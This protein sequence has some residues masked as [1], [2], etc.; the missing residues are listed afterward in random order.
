MGMCACV[1]MGIC[2]WACVRGYVCMCVHEHVCMG[3]C[4]WVCV[5]GHV[6]MCVHGYLCVGMCAWVCVY[7]CVCMGVCAW[8]RVYG[9]VC[10][11]MCACV[12]VCSSLIIITA[13]PH[14]PIHQ[15]PKMRYKVLWV[16]CVEHS[17][18]NECPLSLDRSVFMVPF[19]VLSAA[20]LVGAEKGV[21]SCARP[22]QFIVQVAHLLARVF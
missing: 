20:G 18:C 10:M 5:D 7:G 6:C 3:V 9:C 1:C 16:P 19:V 2:V 13:P 11:G 22:T 4:G 8:V 14:S 15:N 12:H 21:S 17:R